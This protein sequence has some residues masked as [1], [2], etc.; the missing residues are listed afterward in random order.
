MKIVVMGFVLAAAQIG[1]ACVQQEAQF[2]G[3]VVSHKKEAV[4]QYIVD[5][6]FE[7]DYSMF[8]VSRT[9]PLVIGE[10][11]GLRFSDRDCALKNGDQVSGVLVKK[12]GV[13]V[14]E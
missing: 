1:F 3:S 5:C 6:S 8:N 10:V 11:S 12:D 7:I 4:D 13:V 2:I 9:C 14:I